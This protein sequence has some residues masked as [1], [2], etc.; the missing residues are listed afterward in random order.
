MAKK[1]SGHVGKVQ[2]HCNREGEECKSNPDINKARSSENYA[3]IH[4][5]DWRESISKRLEAAGIK[6]IRKNA[7]LYVDGFYGG[8]PEF[9]KSLDLAGQKEYFTA[10]LEWIKNRYGTEN[11]I[12]AVVHM[13]EA[14]PHMHF[15]FVPITRDGRL[16]AKELLGGPQDMVKFQDAIH[17]EV[18]AKFGLERGKS[19]RETRR[20]HVPSSD[21]KAQME[22]DKVAIAAEIEDGRGEL[23]GLQLR[24]AEAAAVVEPLEQDV[25]RLTEQKIQLNTD[26]AGLYK[27]IEGMTRDEE[28]YKRQVKA[29]QAELEKLLTEQNRKRIEEMDRRLR[30]EEAKKLKEMDNRHAAVIAS[31]HNLRGAPMN[32]PPR[33]E[34]SRFF[35]RVFDPEYEKVLARLGGPEKSGKGIAD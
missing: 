7:V 26:I 20:R 34:E 3:L 33:G 15:Q 23:A 13:D 35:Q 6:K 10:G 5:S 16:C 30:E 24:R 12:S 1:G 11:V 21:Y 9:I 28:E 14:T 2:S 29:K 4:S 19:R 8:S 17:A 18:F 25:A 31:V 22:R 32:S 27:Q